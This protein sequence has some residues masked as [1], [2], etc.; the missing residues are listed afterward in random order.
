M[1][2]RDRYAEENR[3]YKIDVIQNDPFYGNQWGLHRINV[4]EAWKITEGSRDIIVGL[5]DTGIDYLHP[6]LKNNIWIN[7][8]E[9]INRDGKFTEEDLNG[10]D[11]DG[12]GYTDD[13]IGW[14]FTDAISYPDNGDFMDEDN[15]PMDEAGHGTLMAGIIAAVKDNGIGV[16]GVAPNVK[17]MNIKAGTAEGYLEEDDVARAIVYAV[18]NGANVINL[19]FGDAVYSYFLK[20]MVNYAYK[21]GCVVVSSAGNSSSTVP[22]YPSGFSNVISVGA[23]DKNDNLAGFSNFGIDVDIF[24]PGV[25]IISTSLGDGFNSISGTSA[26]SAFVS[27]VAA[28]IISRFE[29][30]DNDE[31]RSII[32][33]SSDVILDSDNNKQLQLKR[34]NA[35]KCLKISEK[36]TAKLELRREKNKVV[37]Y[38]TTSGLTFL[39]YTIMYTAGAGSDNWKVILKDV[40]FQRV[41]DK[42]GEFDL[43]NLPDTTYYFKLIVEGLDKNS[44]ETVV[45]FSLDRTPPEILNIDYG[46]VINKLKEKFYIETYTD[47]PCWITVKFHRVN[48]LFE[49]NEKKFPYFSKKQRIIIGQD[50]VKSDGIVF[51]IIAQNETGLKT[52][53]EEYEITLKE[54]LKLNWNLNIEKTG[55]PAG[56][57]L[58]KSTDFDKDNNREI[59]FTELKNGYIFDRLKIYEWNGSNFQEINIPEIK[60]I[61]RDVADLDN[62]GKPDLML[63]K[64]YETYLYESTVRNRFPD[65]LKMEFPEGFTGIRYFDFNS[66]N[67]PEIVG[68][69]ENVIY[70]AKFDNGDISLY[71]SLVNETNGVNELKIPYCEISDLDG[72][73][74]VEILSGDNDGDII[75]YE[76]HTGK[77]N[78]EWSFRLPNNGSVDFLSTGDYDGD[79]KNEF[80]AGSYSDKNFKY[81]ENAETGLWNFYIFKSK[82]FN[83]YRKIWE[84]TILGVAPP[85]IFLSG[86]YSG[87]IDAGQDDEIVISVYPDLYFIDRDDI[88]DNFYFVSRVEGSRTGKFLIDDF[89]N[90]G[91][92]ELFVNIDNSIARI[93]KRME[94]MPVSPYNFT[95]IPVDTDI[96]KLQ[97]EYNNVSKFLIYKGLEK[98]NILQYAETGERFYIDSTVKKNKEYWYGVCSID[99]TYEIPLSEI[100]GPVKVIPHLKVS[101]VDAEF[102]PPEQIIVNFDGV[103]DKTA[104]NIKNYMFY[105]ENP[106]LY[107]SLLIN[108]E[109]SVLLTLK[110][111]FSKKGIYRVKVSENVR[112]F[113]GM[114][115]NNVKNFA[116]FY[117]SVLTEDFYIE[118]ASIVDK[119]TIKIKFNMPVDKETASEK[120][121]YS[122]EP[123]ID[124]YNIEIKSDK[125]DEV[126]LNLVP[127][128]PVGAFGVDYKIV[129]VNVKSFNGIIIN[130]GNS[131]TIR[132]VS[133]THLTL[134]TN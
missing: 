57:F 129:V 128:K 52:E 122:L 80:I 21:N 7:T 72:D 48:N 62:N 42:L 35:E 93:E 87:N 84:T 4:E 60:A 91:I 95:C 5:V 116:D 99:S 38:G 68:K 66:D 8:G 12:N 54:S 1:C 61:P 33:S 45:R 133:Y 101:V 30:A 109:K 134:P 92:N 67:K 117:V 44:C 81:V 29:N 78:M 88:I 27:G 3:A 56:Y 77:S 6:D 110:N 85:D 36:L 70:L 23:T 98:D 13:I 115:I 103:L 40:P 22:H 55:F 31:I 89:N 94:S 18:N 20:D 32:T 11:D 132:T 16:I 118:Y 113:S 58:Y 2:I 97:W 71:D 47:E 111:S 9:D 74:N 43:S 90:N 120:S 10:I 123:D 37:F 83:D 64:G 50:E 79:G 19:S 34:L 59:I 82:S 28:L 46:I 104:E 73:N 127:N 17:I 41:N 112:D 106:G 105:P 51:S 100:V 15:D 25:N 126:Y 96:V 75:V 86:I 102:V 49:V 63:T 124:I 131:F 125:P 107:S 26:S 119:N 114:N 108:Q 69:K 121:N 76:Y 24:A 65:R 39:H 130:K 14:D 53:S